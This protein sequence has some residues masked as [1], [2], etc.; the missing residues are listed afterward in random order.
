MY[1][2]NYNQTHLKNGLKSIFNTRITIK[3]M[4]DLSA[5]FG[6]EIPFPS[7][8]WITQSEWDL[9][10]RYYYQFVIDGIFDTKKGTMFL[11][12]IIARFMITFPS[13][14]IEKQEI[15]RIPAKKQGLKLKQF[16]GLKSVKSLPKQFF[17][18][19]LFT[20]RDNVFWALK[21]NF[22]IQL[23]RGNISYETLEDFAFANFEDKAKDRSTLRAKCR[24]IYN[25]YAD[26]NFETR[27]R[28]KYKNHQHYLEE[29]MAT[30]QQNMAK[31]N[32]KRKEDCRRV[33]V[34]LITGLTSFEY[35]KQNG[36]WNV[37]KLAKDTKLT[38]KTIY[39]YLEEFK[40]NL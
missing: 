20:K 5:N 3:S 36:E 14:G 24:S 13:S 10:T 16:Q 7:W 18:T 23:E 25:Y 32:N 29:T 2:Y 33:I 30:R 8:H 11:N 9:K 21:I 26:R 37:S 31:I 17:K 40:S 4:E 39:K 35:K 34:G 15:K 28:G 22:E 19:N 6:N 27:T 12:D 38:R 1:I